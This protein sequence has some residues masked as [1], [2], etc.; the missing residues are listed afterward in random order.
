MAIEGHPER[1]LGCIASSMSL[2]S[3]SQQLGQRD[4]WQGKLGQL[5]CILTSFQRATD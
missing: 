3:L 4:G 5:V 2:S 1:L